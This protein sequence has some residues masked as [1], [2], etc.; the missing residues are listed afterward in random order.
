M[1][2][3]HLLPALEVLLGP[4]AGDVLQAAAGAAGGE[5]VALSRQ[6]VLYRPGEQASVRYAAEVSWAGALPVEETLV[7]VTTVEGPPQG[8]LVVAAGELAVG[9]FRYPDDP[10]LPG[11]R[12]ATSPAAVAEKL[13]IGSPEPRLTVRTYRPGRRAVVRVRDE[14]LSGD[15]VD[16][17]LKVVPPDEAGRLRDGLV[18]LRRHLPVPGVA[19]S[20]PDLG[21]VVLEA[22]PGRT[23]RDVLLAGNRADV[24]RLPD[25]RAILELLD[26]FPRP[27][28]D[29]PRRRGP[30]A[31]AAGHAGLLAA[32]L[33][34][35]RER[36]SDLV[37]RL[38]DRPSGRAADAVHGDLHEAQLLV[39]GAR[40][41]GVLDLDD[42]GRG[43]RV[44]DLATMLGHLLTLALAMPTRRDRIRRYAATLQPAF[45]ESVD[46][47]VLRRS[48]AATIMGLATGPFRVQQ[49]SWRR[50]SLARIALA[51]A[52][53]AAS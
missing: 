51:E 12:L 11:L 43:H 39:D 35:E 24:A 4:G 50:R 7:A 1:V 40:I 33:P 20:W 22:L 48:T 37:R 6:Q 26:R 44:D 17:Y 21:V 46:P 3:D 47:D 30:I 18:D 45:V 32:V 41:S 13:G 2:R 8:T 49:R 25:G 10:G 42:S 29:A 23:I 5:I 19:A 15:P 53:L 14:T 27:A 9:V 36:L 16:R 34:A 31:R 28:P 38:G 52:H